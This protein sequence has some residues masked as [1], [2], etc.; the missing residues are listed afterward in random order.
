M[1]NN[2]QKESKN[3]EEGTRADGGIKSQVRMIH[4]IGS[5]IP[6]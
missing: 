5:D 2:D 4:P 3:N 1:V 6:R